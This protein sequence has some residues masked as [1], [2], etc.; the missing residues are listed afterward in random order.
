MAVPSAVLHAEADLQSNLE[1]LDVAAF[2]VASDLRN[3]VPV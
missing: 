2:D 1:M 3:L